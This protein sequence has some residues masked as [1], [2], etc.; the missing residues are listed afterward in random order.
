M[1]DSRRSPSQFSESPRTLVLTLPIASSPLTQLLMNSW[2]LNPPGSDPLC[3]LLRQTFNFLSFFFFSRRQ[4]L[5]YKV[6]SMKLGQQGL[7]GA[8]PLNDLWTRFLTE[9][10]GDILHVHLKELLYIG[11]EGKYITKCELFFTLGAHTLGR[12]FFFIILFS[13]LCFV[14]FNK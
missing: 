3:K 8:K 5:D 1:A 13:L 11:R 6:Y 12:L 14:F 9:G 4:N 10:P 7:T 2:I